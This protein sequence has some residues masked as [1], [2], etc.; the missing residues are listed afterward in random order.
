MV[1]AAAE[2]DRTID[3]N[4]IILSALERGLAMQDIKRM[5]LGHVV[6]FVIDYN[7]R[8]KNAEEKAERQS[9]AKHYRLASKDEVDAWLKG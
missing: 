8:Q 9:K 1:Q 5:S 3:L 4:T 6:D 2:K 7:K